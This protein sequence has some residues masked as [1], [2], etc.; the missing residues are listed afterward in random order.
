MLAMSFTNKATKKNIIVIQPVGNTISSTT[1]SE[2]ARIIS[3]R[4]KDFGIDKTEVTVIPENN[5]IK[6]IEVN[7]SDTI[8]AKKLITNQGRIEFCKPYNIEDLRN[9]LK[10]DNR[11]FNLFNEETVYDSDIKIGCIPL[12][13]KE[14]INEYLN[15]TGNDK[16]CRYVWSNVS[17]SAEVCMYALKSEF[18]KESLLT[19]ND[20][21]SVKVNRNKSSKYWYID[22]SFKKTAIKVWSDITKQNIGN[23]IAIV[24]D[25]HVICSPV[26]NTIIE[27]G[28]CS[29]TG[30]FSEQEVKLFAAFGNYGELPVSFCV[31]K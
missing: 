8:M 1:L 16:K 10:N 15:T 5:Q 29:I 12:S 3:N 20:L 19:G 6:I 21:D 26:I 25:D 17:D 13:K 11:L 30:T 22:F 9:L 18:D 7:D 27:S 31:V 4:L 2:S 23:S 24:V 28:K 14:K